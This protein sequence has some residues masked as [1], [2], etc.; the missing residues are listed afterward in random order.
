M[1]ATPVQ[2]NKKDTAIN[3]GKREGGKSAKTCGGFFMCAGISLKIRHFYKWCKIGFTFFLFLF[4]LHTLIGEQ[5]QNA[6][7]CQTQMCQPKVLQMAPSQVNIWPKSPP[8]FSGPKS[9][10]VINYRKAS[11]WLRTWGTL[12][13]SKG[14]QALIKNLPLARRKAGAEERRKLGLFQQR[15]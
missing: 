15:S 3:L 13:Q 1:W 8:N 6:D 11:V 7:T 4:F 2:S 14:S 12:K 9:G 5:S 10:K